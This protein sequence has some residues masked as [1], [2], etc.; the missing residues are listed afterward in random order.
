VEL[1]RALR[2]TRSRA[3]L[4]RRLG[5]RS[6]VVHRWE[7]R[8]SWPTAARF[9]QVH[10]RLTPGSAPCFERFFQRPPTWLSEHAPES[11]E[12]VAAFLRELR[13]KT[14]IAALAEQSGYSRYQVSRWLGASTQPSL[15]EFLCLVEAASRRVLDLVA[16][17]I[18]PAR[19]PS[20]AGRWQLLESARAAG[21]QKPWSH[22]VLRALEIEPQP[23]TSVAQIAQMVAR[24]GIDRDTI[25]DCLNTLR[26]TGQVTKRRGRFALQTK[27]TV[28][29]SRDPELARS[30]KTTWTSTAL[31][32]LEQNAP[33]NFGYS[34][35]AVSRKDLRRL[36]D[37]HL[38]YV[39][40][41]QE[42]I[43]SSEPSEC[44]GLYCS[45]LLDLAAEDNVL[46]YAEAN[47]RSP[48]RLGT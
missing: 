35:F 46:A 44:V 20:V 15:P 18:D 37:L 17:M 41:M 9:L 5:Y 33:G 32:R 30:L 11:P 45:Q 7:T 22:A 48:R 8:R 34:L 2:G 12:G 4:S 31:R 26:A 29:T 21:Y 47:V 14:S 19:L 42:L 38:E 36:R 10:R 24:L 16:L 1:L 6:N 23:A 39:R 3:E 40:A 27:T 13:G 43:A 25:V 28:N